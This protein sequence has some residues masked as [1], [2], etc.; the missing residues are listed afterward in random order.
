[1]KGPRDLLG[2]KARLSLALNAAFSTIATTMRSLLLLALAPVATATYFGPSDPPTCHVDTAG[3]TI[4][5]YKH[6]LHQSFKCTHQGTKC[7][8]TNSH[9]THHKGGCKEFDHTDGS[10]HNTSGDCS[11]TGRSPTHGGWSGW[12][13][14]SMA[15]AQAPQ[16]KLFGWK[17]R[18]P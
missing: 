13:A 3:R 4:V 16:K 8:C 7:T 9:P 5:H 6:G 2:P 1:M 18:P 11:V 14:Y 10:D 17:P 15:R 12:S